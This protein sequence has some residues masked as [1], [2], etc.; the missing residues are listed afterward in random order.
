M[1]EDFRP[2]PNCEN[3]F[4]SNLGRVKKN[5]KIIRTAVNKR[6]GYVGV[7]LY[8]GDFHAYVHLHKLVCLAFVENLNP[9][10][11]NEVD[12]IDNNKNNNCASNLRWCSKSDNLKN[13]KGY[14]NT[15]KKYISQRGD[16]FI[17]QFNGSGYCK[18]FNTLEEAMEARKDL[19]LVKNISWR[20][21]Y[22]N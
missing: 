22:D 3:Y 17:L 10:F 15:G 8:D 4:V 14:S 21:D 18:Q 19:L 13:R 6:T 20:D 5:D 1:T 12:H 7:N 9:D 2:V 11:F 16:K